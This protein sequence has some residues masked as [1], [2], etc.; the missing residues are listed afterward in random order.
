[1]TTQSDVAAPSIIWLHTVAF[2]CVLLLATP[3][4]WAQASPF[5]VGAQSLV[6]D[7][8]AIATPIAIILVMVLGIVAATGR[9][10]WG[11]PIGVLIGI[12]VIFGAPQFVAWIRGLFGV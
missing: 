2:G 9:I 3:L 6:T 5:H 4:V 8:V 7:I 1:M 12:A 11:W 10:S